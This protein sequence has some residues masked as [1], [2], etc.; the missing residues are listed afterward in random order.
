MRSGERQRKQTARTPEGDNGVND[1]RINLRGERISSRLYRLCNKGTGHLAGLG[2]HET[3]QLAA[4]NGEVRGQRGAGDAALFA[5]GGIGT[6]RHIDLA[7]FYDNTTSATEPPLPMDRILVLLTFAKET[8]KSVEGELTAFETLKGAS[9]AESCDGSIDIVIG[10]AVA[11]LIDAST[12]NGGADD[13]AAATNSDA[14]ASE[15]GSSPDEPALT[16]QR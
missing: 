14:G 13:D 5:V 3:P 12:D 4:V 11:T 7:Q 6:V 8:V 15:P 2:H 9:G 16:C 1:E 10:E